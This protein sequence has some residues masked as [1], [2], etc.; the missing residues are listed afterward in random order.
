M[1]VTDFWHRQ[2]ASA[3]PVRDAG[4]ASE[5]TPGQNAGFVVC[6][7]RMWLPE[8]HWW[9]FVVRGTFIYLFL[10][11]ILRVTGKRQ[12]GQL[13]PFD[14]ILLLVL[15]NSVQNAMVGSDTSILGGC[16]TATTL[17]ALNGLVSWI[18]FKSKWFEALVEGRPIRLIHDG[19][20][21]ADNLR[22]AKLTIHELNAAMRAAGVATYECVHVAMLENTGSISIVRREKPPEPA[23]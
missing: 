12:V 5:P 20:V 14:L 3:D 2:R 13:A 21:D 7:G 16:I 9:T 19:H 22:K 6:S 1:R 4:V 10:L 17:I 18:T 23:A 11:I 8:L 15:S